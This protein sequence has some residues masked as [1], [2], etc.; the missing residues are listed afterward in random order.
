MIG[1]LNGY[2]RF[3]STRVQFSD[4]LFDKVTYNKW[5]G[6]GWY[7]HCAAADNTMLVVIPAFELEEKLHELNRKV[8]DLIGDAQDRQNESS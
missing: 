2:W 3:Y 8:D 5:R 7:W 6:A 4:H 1:L